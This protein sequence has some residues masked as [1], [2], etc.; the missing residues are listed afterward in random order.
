MF[1]ERYELFIV[2][3][4]RFRNHNKIAERTAVY[5]GLADLSQVDRETRFFFLK[6][7]RRRRERVTEVPNVFAIEHKESRSKNKKPSTASA[8]ESPKCRRHKVRVR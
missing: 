4:L 1:L 5:L 8:S 2:Y 3:Y 6:T 7:E